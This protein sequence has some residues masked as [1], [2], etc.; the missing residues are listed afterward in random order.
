MFKT[1][2]KHF[3]KLPYIS[4]NVYSIGKGF[5]QASVNFLKS[6]ITIYTS[7]PP[8]TLSI[9]QGSINILLT[10]RKIRNTTNNDWF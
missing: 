6:K 4:T 2:N 7:S 1:K 9:I 10:N 8:S 5:P 3:L